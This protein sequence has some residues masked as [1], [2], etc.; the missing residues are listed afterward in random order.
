ML[1]CY[2]ACH[3]VKWHTKNT[4]YQLRLVYKMLGVSISL[5]RC[6][7]REAFCV[8]VVEKEMEVFK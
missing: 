5:N 7:I 8:T 3:L 1:A 4:S 2:I 6:S